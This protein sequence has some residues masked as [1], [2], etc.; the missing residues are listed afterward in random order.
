MLSL[1]SKQINYFIPCIWNV[2]SQLKVVGIKNY[3]HKA[4]YVVFV[5]IVVAVLRHI[6]IQWVKHNATVKF[7]SWN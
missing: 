5:Y 7:A 4:T 2:F 1:N 6:A 3:M